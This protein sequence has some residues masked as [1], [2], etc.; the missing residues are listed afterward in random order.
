MF[1]KEAEKYTKERAKEL[2]INDCC[3]AYYAMQRAYQYGAEFGY[4]KGYHDAEEHYMNVIDSQ[5]KL[6]EESKAKEWHEIESKVTPKREISKQFM[7]KNKEKVLL[8][9]HFSGD[10]E[11]HISDG[12][13]DA[14]DFE[15]HIANNPKY[16]I[17][18]VIAWKEIVL[19]ELKESE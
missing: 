13:Y 12:Y 3:L 6:V 17:V 8:K 5:H 2:D 1:E 14:Y 11:V 7:P 16:R 18:C 15:F 10:D 4:N 19:P 9:Y